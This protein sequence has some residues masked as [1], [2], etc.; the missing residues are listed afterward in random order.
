L[1]QHDANLLCETAFEE[2]LVHWRDVLLDNTKN[3][4]DLVTPK[5]ARQFP[6]AA[7]AMALISDMKKRQII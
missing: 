1:S 6:A 4:K 3:T 2:V 5:L 7:K